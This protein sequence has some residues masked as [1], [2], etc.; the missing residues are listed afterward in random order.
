MGTMFLGLT[1]TC[2]RCHD[3]KYDPVTQRHFF[4]L[5][6]FFNNIAEAGLGPE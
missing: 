2:S 6:A 3:H 1:L 4:S 5:F